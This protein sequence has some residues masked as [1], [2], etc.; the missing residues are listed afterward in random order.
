M[1][2][3]VTLCNLDVIRTTLA[4]QIARDLP[5]LSGA[6]LANVLNEGALEAVR[7]DATS[8]SAADIYNA[9]DRILQVQLHFPQCCGP[10]HLLRSQFS[11][12]SNEYSTSAQA[13]GSDVHLLFMGTGHPVNLV[14]QRRVRSTTSMLLL[15]AA[16]GTA[17]AAAGPAGRE[18]GAGGARGGQGAGGHAAARPHPVPGAHRARVHGAPRRVRPGERW[19]LTLSCILG[20]PSG[21]DS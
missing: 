5:G 19:P 7:R 18:A 2:E 9:V 17:A 3:V 8:I 11:K 13:S 6:E 21:P 14:P 20:Q 12:P 1:R 16:G 15:V 4:P 10:V